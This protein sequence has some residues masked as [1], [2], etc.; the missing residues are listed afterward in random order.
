MKIRTDF[1]TNSS[2]SSYIVS[3]KE[4]KSIPNE[5]RNFI[6]EVT[7]ENICE[8]MEEMYDYNCGYY[9]EEELQKVKE[10]FNFTDEQ[11]TALRLANDADALENYMKVRELL[12]KGEKVYIAYTGDYC[13]GYSTEIYNFLEGSEQIAYNRF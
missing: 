10:F 1:V 3:F 9:R 4:E 5:L 7:K 13:G 8:E 6:K 2:S 11:L 12:D